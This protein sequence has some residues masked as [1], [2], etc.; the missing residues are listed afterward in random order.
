[1]KEIEKQK[2]KTTMNRTPEELKK[3]TAGN[4]ENL[5]AVISTGKDNTRE[6]WRGS[7]LF[8]SPKR[9]FS[10]SHISQDRWDNIFKKDND[11]EDV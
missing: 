5:Q 1:M 4:K 11:K 10:F 3:N 9:T 8:K 7:E 2:P 6:D